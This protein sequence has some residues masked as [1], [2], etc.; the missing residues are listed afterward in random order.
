MPSPF[1]LGLSCW[2]EGRKE[3]EALPDIYISQGKEKQQLLEQW[4]PNVGL[5]LATSAFSQ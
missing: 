4:F 3:E 5:G 2:D 1:Q